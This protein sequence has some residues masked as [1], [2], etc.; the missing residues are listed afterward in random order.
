MVKINKSKL[1]HV[2]VFKTWK[3]Y[4]FCSE[5]DRKR[6]TTL[7]AP[8]DYYTFNPLFSYFPQHFPF[9]PETW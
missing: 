7:I 1:K 3:F 6:L 9:S 5:N 2:A 4:W 8:T